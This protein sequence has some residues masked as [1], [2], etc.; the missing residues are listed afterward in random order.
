[1]AL[2]TLRET[3]GPSGGSRDTPHCGWA[4]VC[5]LPP[6]T[7]ASGNWSSH[8]PFSFNLIL[9]A[10]N[11]HLLLFRC[12]VISHHG[13]WRPAAKSQDPGAWS[14]GGPAN[15]TLAPTPSHNQGWGFLVEMACGSLR[16]RNF[17]TESLPETSRTERRPQ[18]LLL[19]RPPPARAPRPSRVCTLT[20]RAPRRA[21]TRAHS[22]ALPRPA[23]ASSSRMRRQTPRR[24]CHPSAPAARRPLGGQVREFSSRLS[25]IS[26]PLCGQETDF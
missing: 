17:C 21:P 22:P 13:S 7:A 15:R 18:A 12:G 2:V 9:K 16:P 1:M 25:G 6:A 24:L 26:F 3:V 8:F 5:G 20:P 14:R 4:P 11:A 10:P 19:S 23:A